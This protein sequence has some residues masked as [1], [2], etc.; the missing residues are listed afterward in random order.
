MALKKHISINFIIA[1]AEKI[2]LKN[3][4]LKKTYTFASNTKVNGKEFS[5]R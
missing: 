2:T 5:Y 3:P 1:T 4:Y